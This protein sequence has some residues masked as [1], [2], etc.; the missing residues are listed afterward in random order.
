ME[1]KLL[2]RRSGKPAAAESHR[3][4]ARGGRGKSY[5]YVSLLGL[6][7]VDPAD[8]VRR[9]KEGL[10]FGSLETFQENTR[11]STADVASLVSIPPRTLQ[12]RKS[13]GRLDPNESD[14]LLR[15]ARLF[16]KAL[17]LFEGDAEAAQDWFHR[18][19]RGLGGEPPI[20]LAVTD[21]GTREVEALIDRLEHGVIA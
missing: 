20:E 19:A 17:D 7:D 15:V 9:I 4:P 8:I 14:R 21:L 13:E 18:P 5:R 6:E 11:L 3:K 2:K 12:R 1:H 10:A 16:A